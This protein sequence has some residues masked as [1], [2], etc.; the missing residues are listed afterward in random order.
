MLY[1]IDVVV[2][3]PGGVD[4]AIVR[5]A[6]AQMGPYDDT[7]YGE[8][9]RAAELDLYGKIR[10]GHAPEVIGRAIADALTVPAPKARYAIVKNKVR[11]WVIPQSLPKR[12]VDRV[13]AKK[14]GLMPKN[15]KSSVRN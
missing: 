15:F 14:F 11:D 3:G 8:S 12:T 13:I 9:M 4:T 6:E 1:E 7:D 5:K 2:I 10:A